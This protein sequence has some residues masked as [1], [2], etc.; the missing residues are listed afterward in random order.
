MVFPFGYGTY[1]LRVVL[2]PEMPEKQEK[3][4]QYQPE[5]VSV[6]E[7]V[8]DLMRLADVI[9]KDK[10]ISL[11]LL[12]NKDLTVYCDSSLLKIS[13]RNVI[14]NAIKFTPEKGT[15]MIRTEKEEGHVT[16]E[17]TDTGVGMDHEQIEKILS[18]MA[19]STRGTS[20]ERGTGLGLLV[21]KDLVKMNKG[22][23]Q[24]KSKPGRG[25]SVIFSLPGKP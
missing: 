12:I 6:A 22:T 19:E 18:E 24:I 1:R 11:E 25:T 23:L 3:H 13:L 4:L 10:K 21:V 15:V 5:I 9:A 20:G 17:V 7:V 2:P 16:I 14:T 8:H